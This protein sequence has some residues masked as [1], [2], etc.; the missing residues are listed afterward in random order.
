VTISLG[1]RPKLAAFL[2]SGR[3]LESRSSWN[4]LMIDETQLKTNE[5]AKQNDEFSAG[6]R[7]SVQRIAR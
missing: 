6:V 4:L 5:K 2:L 7:G 1:K 3:E